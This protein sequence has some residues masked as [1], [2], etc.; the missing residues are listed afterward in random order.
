M[1]EIIFSGHVNKESKLTIY[2]KELFSIQLSKFN[3]SSV[4]III[5][6]KQNKFNDSFRDYYFAVIVNE[7]QKA[8]LSTGVIKS[9]KDIDY[10]LRGLFLFEE[11]IDE[12]TGEY[13]K[14]LHT[15]RKGDTKVSSK[16]MKEYCELCI[17]F[18]AVNLEWSI[19]YPNED[20][21]IEQMTERQRNFN[22][23]SNNL[24]F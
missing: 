16:M 19:P 22:Y 1:K 4:D 11:I 23:K 12:E 10:E 3:N 8:Y 13:E 9:K 18:S 24:T 5:R 6:E 15:L 7:V 17:I 21:T 2:Q 20:L 14:M